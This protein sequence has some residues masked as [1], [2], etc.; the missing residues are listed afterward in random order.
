[1]KTSIYDHCDLVTLGMLA[2]RFDPLV[3]TLLGNSWLVERSGIRRVEE[4]D[5]WQPS[6][7]AHVDLAAVE[8]VAMHYG[9]FPLTI[10]PIDE[11]VRALDE[12]LRAHGLPS[13]AF[14]AIDHG[15]SERIA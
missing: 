14:R 11:P 9:T 13:S 7:Q 10:E 3:V 6:R 15:A 1:M 8:S 5:W 4:L 12:A 2:E